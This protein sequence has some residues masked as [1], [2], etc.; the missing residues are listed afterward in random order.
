MQLEEDLISIIVPVYNVETYLKQCIDSLLNQ[1]YQN[2]EIILVDDGS[3][4]NSGKM[5]EDYASK[6]S[7]IKVIHKENAGLGM[8]RNTGLEHVNGTYVAFF[9][10]DDWA[11]VDLIERLYKGLKQSCCD[12]CKGGY[13][14]VTDSG[15]IVAVRGFENELFEGKAAKEEMLPRMIGSCP[16]KQDSIE[17][18]ACG[19][20]YRVSNIIEHDLRFPSERELISEDLV[21]NIDYMQYADGA[22]TISYCGYNYRINLN[23]ITKKYRPQ[24]FEACKIFYNVMREKLIKLGYGQE[25]IYRLQRILFVYMRGCVSQERKGLSNLNRKERLNR[26]KEICRDEVVQKMLE[27]YPINRMG[28]K[29]IKQI[30]FLKILQWKMHYVLYV[31]TSLRLFD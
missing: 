1:T 22:C 11:E 28:I 9:D 29:Q 6:Y 31:L 13:K 19:T 8:A 23:S 5:C 16:E 20:L 15:D 10:S 12:V 2:I 25:T 27:E 18:S 30:C 4:D 26:I 7:N 3:P 17:M 24:K 14:R 21:F